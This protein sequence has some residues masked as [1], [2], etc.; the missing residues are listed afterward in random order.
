[1]LSLE[2][3]KRLT[4]FLGE[5]WHDV[6]PDFYVQFPSRCRVCKRV[7]AFYDDYRLDF[8]DWRV[9]GRLV[10]KVGG[11]VATG[12]IVDQYGYNDDEDGICLAIDAYLA[13]G[14]GK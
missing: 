8:N 2:Q 4:E 1:M 14:E 7:I 6:P 5:C 9:R 11:I 13:K 3:R 12:R 10:E